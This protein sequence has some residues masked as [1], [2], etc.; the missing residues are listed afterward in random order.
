MPTKCKIEIK[1]GRN[2]EQ[3]K[4]KKAIT[5]RLIS[6]LL[7]ATI[8]KRCLSNSGGEVFWLIE[9]KKWMKRHILILILI[10]SIIF[11]SWRLTYICKSERKGERDKYKLH[12]IHYSPH[13]RNGF[14]MEYMFQKTDEMILSMYYA[15]QCCGFLLCHAFCWN[16]FH[17]GYVFTLI[18]ATS[19]FVQ[20]IIKIVLIPIAQSF[21]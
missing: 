10:E 17:F 7:D 6:Q 5:Y 18:F 16:P 14:E 2:W 11:V 1:A 3:K 8:Q 4:W 20:N 15:N 21:V 9:I 13:M 12:I 19:Y